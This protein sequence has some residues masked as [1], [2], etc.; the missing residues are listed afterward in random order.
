MSVTNEPN[1]DGTLMR[2]VF[3]SSALRAAL[4]AGSLLDIVMGTGLIIDSTWLL[5]FV[6]MPK[7]LN[8]PTEFWPHYVAVFLLVLP[9]FYLLAARDLARYR[10]NIWGAVY[11]RLLGF[12]FY[13]ICFARRGREGVFLGLAVMNVLFAIYYWLALRRLPAPTSIGARPRR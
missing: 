4:V 3:G 11:G 9:W 7:G 2:S 1:Q 10:G 13:A 8:D 6:K 5:E 12:G